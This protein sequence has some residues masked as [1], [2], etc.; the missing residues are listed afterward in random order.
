MPAVPC[1]LANPDSD[2]HAYISSRPTRQQAPRAQLELYSPQDDKCVPELA[3]YAILWFSVTR[4][5]KILSWLNQDASVEYLLLK[6]ME[7]RNY[8]SS[9]GA[10]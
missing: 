4:S 7:W 6:I 8:S 1:L 3:C 9:A 10:T 5:L 2:C